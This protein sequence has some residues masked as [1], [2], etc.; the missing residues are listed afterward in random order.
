MKTVHLLIPDLFLAENFAAEVCAGLSVPALEKMLARGHSETLAPVALESKLCELFGAR[1]E[2]ARDQT[3]APVAPIS[4]AFDGL[5]AGCWLRADPVHLSLQREQMLLLPDLQISAEEAA[6][7]CASLNLHF[8]GQG[9]EFFAPHPQRW[10]VRLAALPDI[11]T[12]PPSQALGRNVHGL[13]PRGGQALRWHQVFNEIQMLLYA[14]PLNQAREARGELTINSVWFWGGGDSSLV[15]QNNYQGV[16]FDKVLA[17]EVLAEMFAAAAQIPYTG[18]P[19]QW[20]D[21]KNISRQLLVWTGLSSALRRGDFAA[22][23]AALQAFESG[24][25]Q[26]L[27]Q[28]L[29]S[30]KITQLRLD[31]LAGDS[32]R[33]VQLTR[34]DTWAL[35]RHSKRLDEY[36]RA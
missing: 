35:W 19:A 22:W 32:T 30:G 23:R 33:R 11:E 24:C 20:R 27:W 34:G 14:H 13:L 1:G 36:S 29:W 31:I 8:A 10:Y 28:A 15:A 21:E 7:M 18:W 17:D 9:M 6:Q 4:A 16:P 3:A 12:V 2:M 5:G 26:P 25:A